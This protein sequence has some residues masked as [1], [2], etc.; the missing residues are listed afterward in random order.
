[1]YYR[2]LQFFFFVSSLRNYSRVSREGYFCRLYFFRSKAFSPRL[3]LID[4]FAKKSLKLALCKAFSLAVVNAVELSSS[5][6]VNRIS[7]KG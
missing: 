4:S 5:A 6:A 7:R 3:K 2:L 1:M